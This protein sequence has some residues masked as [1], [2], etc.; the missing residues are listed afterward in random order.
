MTA[1]TVEPEIDLDGYWQG[2]AKQDV[3]FPNALAEL[4]ES[5]A[6]SCKPKI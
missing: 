3:K 4:I 2:L 1:L 5:Y 6:S